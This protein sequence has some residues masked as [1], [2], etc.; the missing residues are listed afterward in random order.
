MT[1]ILLLTHP[2]ALRRRNRPSAICQVSRR[3]FPAVHIYAKLPAN[4]AGIG[5]HSYLRSASGRISAWK[6]SGGASQGST[7]APG[8]CQR[9]GGGR[10]SS[11]DPTLGTRCRLRALVHITTPDGEILEQK[12]AIPASD[13][14]IVKVPIP[15][16]SFGGPM[17]MVSNHSI[18]WKYPS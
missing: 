4:S 2:C 6:V 7:S 12:A 10:G 14:V 5:V 1:C 8:S 17:A 16:P 15:K 3:P 11:C 9:A 13:E 18:R